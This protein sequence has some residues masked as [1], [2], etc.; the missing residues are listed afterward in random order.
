MLFLPWLHFS[1][2]WFYVRLFSFWGSFLFVLRR[3]FLRSC[4]ISGISGLVCQTYAV[5]KKIWKLLAEIRNI[6]HG[7]VL[8]LFLLL[9]LLYTVLVSNSWSNYIVDILALPYFFLKNLFYDVLIVLRFS[10]AFVNL[11]AFDL[12]WNRFSKWNPNMFH[13]VVSVSILS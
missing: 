3:L 8:H 12:C 13:W 5:Y 10:A 7:H 1:L 9:T 6:R 11:T 4:H 2:C